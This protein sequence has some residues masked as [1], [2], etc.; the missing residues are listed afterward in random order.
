MRFRKWKQ[1]TR[2]GEGCVIAR[3]GGGNGSRGE[4]WGGDGQE[5]REESHP[6]TSPKTIASLFVW[7]E[8][9]PLQSVFTHT[10]VEMGL[11]ISDAGAQP[12][13]EF[14]SIMSGK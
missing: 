14:E 7:G 13:L 12:G 6:P 4:D 8:T 3:G 10:H 5:E 2:G 11:S 9:P 1:H